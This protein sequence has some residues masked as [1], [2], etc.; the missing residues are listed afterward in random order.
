MVEVDIGA[1]RP[2][3]GPRTLTGGRRVAAAAALLTLSSHL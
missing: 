3:A 2:L 1:G